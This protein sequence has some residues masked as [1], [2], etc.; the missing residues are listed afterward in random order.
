[1][2]QN[3]MKKNKLIN[4][5][6]KNITGPIFPS[7]VQSSLK[8]KKGSQNIFKILNKN[9]DEPTGKNKWNR[10][11]HID[12]SHGNIYLWPLSK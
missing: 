8:R 11:Y 10:L 6:D 9:N 5:L 12:E 4:K 7:I 3:F 1:M 2:P